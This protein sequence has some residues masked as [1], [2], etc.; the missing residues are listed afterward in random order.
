MITCYPNQSLLESETESCE[1]S[2]K[3]VFAVLVSSTLGFLSLPLCWVFFTFSIHC[4][5]FHQLELL[6]CSA[7]ASWE[8]SQGCFSQ[9]K[10][11]KWHNI[12]WGSLQFPRFCLATAKIWSDGWTSVTAPCYSSALFDKQRLVHPWGVRAG[13]PKDTKRREARSSTLALLFICF[14]SS[15]WA[16][17]CKLDSQEGCL[18]S[19][20][21]LLQFLDLPLFYFHQLFPS[22]SFSHCFM[23]SFFLF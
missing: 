13:Y 8:P 1:L 9:V 7:S 21:F 16:Y 4:G 17:L 15:P 18:F 3:F 12:C 6:L 2:V 23:D 10:S 11:G 20:R 22:L 14:F 5:S 19:L